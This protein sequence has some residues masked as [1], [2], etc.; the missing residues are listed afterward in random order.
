MEFPSFFCRTTP[1]LPQI[2]VWQLTHLKNIITFRWRFLIAILGLLF[3]DYWNKNMNSCVRLFNLNH[4]AVSLLL[5]LWANNLSDRTYK[6][7]LIYGRY[8][9][10]FAWLC[11][12]VWDINNH[13]FLLRW[14]FT[15]ITVMA[16]KKKKKTG[17]GIKLYSSRI[18]VC[19]CFIFLSAFAQERL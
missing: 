15:I 17:H 16:K 10:Y 11:D 2:L 19:W 1:L 6:N 13:C 9:R 5:W 4:P 18:L 14:N 7:S 8:S 3:Y 12:W